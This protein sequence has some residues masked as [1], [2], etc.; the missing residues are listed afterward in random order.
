[1]VLSEECLDSPGD[2][3]QC[4]EAFLVVIAEDA[5]G[6]YCIEAMDAV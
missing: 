3:W 1:M 2:I 6:I 4:L 5:T